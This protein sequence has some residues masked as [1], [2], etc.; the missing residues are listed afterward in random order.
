M[1]AAVAPIESPQDP[2]ATILQEARG[3]SRTR[4]IELARG[5]PRDPAER[6]ARSHLLGVATARAKSQPDVRRLKAEAAAAVQHAAR[7]CHLEPWISLLGGL[8][9]AELAVQDAV[10]ALFLADRLGPEQVE[11]LSSPWRAT[12]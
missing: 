12:R 8:T 11:R 6:Q 7:A 10:L 9:D 5:Y 3:L 4:I 2:I 1:Q